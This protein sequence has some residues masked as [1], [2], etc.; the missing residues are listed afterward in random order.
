MCSYN[1]IN[2]SYGCQNS[3]LLN[4]VLKA[5]M[6]FQGFVVSD[7]QA[8]HSGAASAAAGLD[9][10]MPGDT[11]FSSGR[12]FWGGNLTL[13]V[14]NGTV[15]AWRLDDMAM[16]IMAAYFKVG[17]T[18]E[19]QVETNFNSW[20]HDA[21]G[22]AHQ[23]AKENW[24]RINHQVDVRAGHAGH[25]REAAAQGTVLKNTGAL[26]LHR[27]KFVAAVGEDAGPNPRGP[28]DC[29]DRGCD[30]GTLAMIWGSGTANFPYLVTPDSA[31]QRQ[32]IEDGSRY[33][34]VLIN[35]AWD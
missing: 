24:R 17:K 1:Q 19:N 28:N 21:D 4:R 20:T 35:Y 27:P 33:E 8:Q 23:A 34:S 10:T 15:P 3:Q 13:A 14:L 22:F 11:V 18:V 32:A 9:M 25:I 5:E 26:P 29:A 6:G 31:L 7:W 30:D 2:N 12:S 16:R